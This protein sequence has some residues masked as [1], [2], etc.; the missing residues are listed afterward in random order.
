LL[1]YV[2]II[3]RTNNTGCDALMRDAVRAA[4]AAAAATAAAAAVTNSIPS[5]PGMRCA[6]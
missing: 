4:A 1:P 2:P 6:S 5:M 3:R